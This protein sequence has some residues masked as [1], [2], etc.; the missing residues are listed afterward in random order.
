[1]VILARL[2]LKSIWKNAHPDLLKE[3]RKLPLLPAVLIPKLQ[4]HAQATKSS[5]ND[6]PLAPK[7]GRGGAIIAK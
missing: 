6:Q 5:Q 1:L 2:A 4:M 3:L 7:L